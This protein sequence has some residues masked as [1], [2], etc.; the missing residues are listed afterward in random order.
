MELVTK[1]GVII[2]KTINSFEN[3]GVF[4]PA[5]M[6]EGKTVHMFYRAVRE[7]NFSTIGYCKLEGPLK[8]IERA[9]EPIFYP[10]T[11]EE[12]QGV[13][14]PRITKIEDTYYL[15]YAAYDGI[16]VFGAY[17]TSKDLKKF[18][19]VKI[20][21]PK[22]TF[23]EY[24]ELIKKNFKKISLMHLMFYNLFN[25][26]RLA[27][28]MKSKIYVWDKNIVFFP[29]KI[30]GKF[31]VLHRLYPSI[32]ILYFNSPSE[33]THEFWKDYISNLQ[34][35][36]VLIPKYKFENGHI[37]AGCPPIETK[38][39]WLLIYHSAQ[40]THKEYTYHAC[41][42]LLDL[43][44][45]KKIIARLKEPLFS[46]TES[47]EKEGYVDDVV[48]PTGTAVFDE[49]LYIYYG[50]ADSS[51]AVASVNINTLLNE[52]KKNKDERKNKI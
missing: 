8:I 38:D 16:N 45:P 3:L 5:I 14:D 21:T 6:Q 7:G 11:P 18:E 47:Y 40:L 10:E 37:G 13:E 2:E 20:I 43:K 48:F 36:I 27:K 50:A 44:N 29:K 19:R 23:E 42:A 35:H 46:P 31:A 12:F 17:A 34:K 15:S 41:A 51:V 32:Q 52:L 9:K 49:E 4:N 30:K 33:L 24:S 26:Y 22:F 28:L 1:H 25:R 39:G